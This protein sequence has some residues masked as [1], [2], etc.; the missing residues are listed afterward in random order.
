MP[1]FPMYMLMKGHGY[2]RKA[3]AV[4]AGLSV[5]HEAYRAYNTCGAYE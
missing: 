1:V 4:P 3:V 2:Q 5:A